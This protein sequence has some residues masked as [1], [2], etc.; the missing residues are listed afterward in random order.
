MEW[1]REHEAYPLLSDLKGKHGFVVPENYFEANSLKLELIDLP[2]L[3]SISK[4]IPFQ[5]PVS[6]FTLSKNEIE[7]KIESENEL[8]E[9]RILSKLN[10]VN[11]LS[12]SNTYFTESKKRIEITLK[13]KGGAKIISLNRRTIWFAAAAVLTIT[14]GLWIFDSFFNSTVTINENCNTLACIEKRELMKYKLDNFDNDELYEMVNTDKLLK[15]L[16][17]KESTDS[18]SNTDSADASLMDYI[19]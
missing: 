18:L 9:F 10:R 6:Y 1:L 14:V 2:V 5:T 4:A 19:E 12:V 3:S 16:N 11:P 13:G 8:E 17:K 15:N 7:D